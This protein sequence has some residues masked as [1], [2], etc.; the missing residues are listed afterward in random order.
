MLTEQNAREV[1]GTTAYDADGDKLGKVGQLFLDD[2]TGRPEFVTVNTGLF[3]TSETFIPVS[4]ATFDGDRLTLPFDKAKVK[5]APN[6]DAEGGHLDQAEEQRL[7]EYYG[8]SYDKGVAGTEADQTYSGTETL[9]P[10]T[11]HDSVTDV[12]GAGR[13]SVAGTGGGVSGQQEYSGVRSE[14]HDT[15]GPTTDDAMT[16]SEEELRVGKT[17]SE[18]GRVRLRKYVTTE[19]ETHTVPVRKERAVL[20]SEP[21][22]DGNVGN[23]TSG[24]DLSDEE[25]EVVLNEEHVTVDKTVTPVERVRL[26]TETTT[27]QE[28][29]TEDVR[30]EHIET[31][32]DVEGRR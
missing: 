26:G 31:E 30:K 29:V 14:G 24:P 5:D 21:I 6:V 27:E 15:S 17:Q 7:Y 25:H 22:T 3:G 11:D 10:D 12:S 4:D 18:A 8:L 13:E 2:Q 23:A 9:A 20:E 16:R 28:T 32:G 1:I 19:Q